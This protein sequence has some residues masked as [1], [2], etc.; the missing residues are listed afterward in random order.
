M[1]LLATDYDGTLLFG[2]ALLQDDLDAIRRWREEGN[3][4]A[5]V[6]GRSH[7]SM[8]KQ[9]AEYGLELDYLVTNNG[10]MIFD[11]DGKNLLATQLDTIT[12][13]DLMFASHE[14]GDVVSYVANDG[15]NRHKVV[16]NPGLPDHRYP[17]M[18]P[19][20][21]EEQI[22]D[23]ANFAQI[24]FSMRDRDAAMEFADKVN[25]YF[26]NSVNAFANNC[27]VDVV[28]NGT[29]KASGLEFITAYST[30]DDDDVYA[31]GDSNNDIPMLEAAAHPAVIAAAPAEVLEVV[32]D[33]VYP[34][35]AAFI[36]DIE[37]SA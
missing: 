21:T 19:D 13:I 34:T 30:L 10:G 29:S 25:M 33:R 12:A 7:E 5:I 9:I 32:D 1:K 15:Y 22:M 11:Q 2:D 17:H 28:P 14:M 24:V 16:V 37:H 36:E 8:M 35:V 23:S 18:Q 26:G 4:F 6:T 31:I 27:V 20:W 3:L